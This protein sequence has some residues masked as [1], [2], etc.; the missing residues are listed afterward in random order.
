M[1]RFKRLK[2]KIGALNASGCDF[3]QILRVLVSYFLLFGD[4]YG[5]VAAVFYDMPKRLKPGFEASNAHGGGPH[6]HATTRLPK[7]QR[8]T[9][10]PD[11]FRT[12][13]GEGS[14]CRRHKLCTYFV[15]LRR[16]FCIEES[17]PVSPEN[18][19][20]ASISGDRFRKRSHY[21]QHDNSQIT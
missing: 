18:C 19:R 13:A 5:N 10:H 17:L 1:V 12:D 7:I 6:V 8:H 3:L 9:D 11:F 15:I 4:C 14:S 21:A 20:D 2:N 16:A